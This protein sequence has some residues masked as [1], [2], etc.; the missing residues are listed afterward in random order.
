[1]QFLRVTVETCTRKT[2]DAGLLS[3]EFPRVAR[4]FRKFL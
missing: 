4:N 3:A 1:L 2:G